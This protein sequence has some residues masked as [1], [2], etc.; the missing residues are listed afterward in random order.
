MQANQRDKNGD[1]YYYY[2][3]LCSVFVDEGD[4]VD[5]GQVI[6]TSDNTGMNAQVTPEHL[7]FGVS[8]ES[9]FYTADNGGTT[10]PQLDFEENLKIGRCATNTACIR[11]AQPISN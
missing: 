11:G 5:V 1:Q 2:A 3:H 9:S 8:E 10:C 7:H 4:K 6:A